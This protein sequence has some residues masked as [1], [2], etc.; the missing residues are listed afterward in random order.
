M[1]VQYA[2]RTESGIW[3]ITY[4]DEAEWAPA[5]RRGTQ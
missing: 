5:A 2:R 3:D 1:R 4:P